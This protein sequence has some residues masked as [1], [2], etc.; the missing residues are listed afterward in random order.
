MTLTRR[1]VGGSVLLT[2]SSGLV[3]LLS[4]ITMP[5]LTR[6]LSPQVYGVAALIGSVVSLSSVIALAGIDTTYL[7]T[8][9]SKQE[10]R[11]PVAEHFCWRFAIFSGLLAAALGGM[12]W[13][14][15]PG[16]SIDHSDGLSAVVAIGIFIAPLSAMA[17]VRA[18]VMGRHSALAT[19]TAVAGFVGAVTSITIAFWRRDVSALLVPMFVGYLSPM[20]MLGMPQLQQLARRSQLTANEGIELIKVGFAGVITAPMYWLLTSSDRWFLQHFHGSDAVGIYSIGYSVAIIGM[21]MNTAVL[22][23]WQPES[24]REYEADEARARISLGALMSRLIAAMAVVWLAATAAG[25]DLVRLLADERFHSAA[26]YVP[27][28]AG[29]VFFYGVLRLATTGLLVA[30]QLK[31]A[32]SWWL[33]GGV[34]CLLL[35]LLLVPQHAG[36]GAAITQSISFAFIAAG[37]LATAQR[38]YRMNLNWIRLAPSLIVIFV[39]G[40]YMLRPWH[41]S[42]A[43]SLLMKLPAGIAVAVGV[44]WAMAPDWCVKGVQ[45]LQKKAL[46]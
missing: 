1:V 44:A 32:A 39:I 34:L 26:R 11:G 5:V 42:A 21:M 23:V 14:A 2:V 18:L 9:H 31:W 13:H 46:R 37:V 35:N 10:P 41:D 3:R 36:M 25:G 28:I 15:L 24:A 33:A 4:V 16:D 38:I 45:L 17:Q 6:L 29:G 43:V 30:K 27:Y 40:L 12:A 20:L 7:R 19:S 8:Y 22:A